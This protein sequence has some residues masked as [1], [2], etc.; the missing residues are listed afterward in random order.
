MCGNRH[1]GMKLQGRLKM[2]IFKVKDNSMY[3]INQ[4]IVYMY[5]FAMASSVR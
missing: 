4:L 1:L 5:K 3:Y 2:R